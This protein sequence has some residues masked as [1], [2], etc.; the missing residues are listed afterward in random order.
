MIFKKSVAFLDRDDT[1]IMDTGYM[2]SQSEIIFL[3]GV[4]EGLE[5]LS[6]RGVDLILVSNQSGVSRG[7]ISEEDVY[8]IEEKMASILES[9]DIKFKNAYYCF[10]GPTEGCTCRKPGSGLILQALNDYGYLPEF[11]CMFGDRETDVEASRRAG[12]LGFQVCKGEF[13]ESV[14]YW[15]ETMGYE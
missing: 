10:H 4:I 13:L 3:P 5:L 9:N 1:L 15:L 12:V 8:K 6:K 7:Y 11:C 14:K 2:D